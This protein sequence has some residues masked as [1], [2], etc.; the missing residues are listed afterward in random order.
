MRASKYMSAYMYAHY[1]L[2]HKVLFF[3]VW[4]YASEICQLITHDRMHKSNA[5]ITYKHS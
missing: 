5:Y 2:A 3:N 1:V 4:K